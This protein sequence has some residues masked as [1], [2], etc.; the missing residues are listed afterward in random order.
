MATCIQQDVAAPSPAS[1]SSHDAVCVAVHIRP[2]VDAE[3]A[4]GCQPC[5][6]VTPGQPQARIFATHLPIMTFA[7][8]P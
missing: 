2:L 3:L 6:T 4:E 1:E 5:L 7:R 8:S